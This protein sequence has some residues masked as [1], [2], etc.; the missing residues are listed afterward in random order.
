MG[1][2]DPNDPEV[3]EVISR[4]K[5]GTIPVV[6]KISDGYLQAAWGNPT[7]DVR[8]GQLPEAY[9]HLRNEHPFHANFDASRLSQA[10]GPF[11]G[12]FFKRDPN[13]PAVAGVNFAKLNSLGA[14]VRQISD[15]GWAQE[16]PTGTDDLY[17]N[18]VRFGVFEDGGPWTHYETPD[19]GDI[20][21]SVDG[22]IN[23]SATVPTT[24][25]DVNGVR[26]LEGTEWVVLPLFTS[27]EIPTTFNPWLQISAH[28]YVDAIPANGLMSFEI[29]GVAL[30]DLYSIGVRMDL[31]GGDLNLSSGEGWASTG[32]THHAG[33]APIGGIQLMPPSIEPV[34][35]SAPPLGYRYIA[36]QSLETGTV[37]LT[38]TESTIA[39]SFPSINWQACYL[40][41]VGYTLTALATVLPDDAADVSV[42]TYSTVDFDV[43]DILYVG[44][45]Q[46]EILTAPANNVFTVGRARN[47]TLHQL[48]NVGTLVRESV[49]ENILRRAYVW[50][51]HNTIE[52]G[53]RLGFI[54]LR[55]GVS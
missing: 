55:K 33:D 42:N 48:H 29:T 46:V 21:Y 27:P 32:R 15:T 54:G 51:T 36:A 8:D 17:W 6:Y 34:G 30:N 13:V 12:L 10:R 50:E 37:V 52:L 38:H 1:T 47:G 5:A 7:F 20:E 11:I 24:Y 35:N 49:T 39:G 19:T 31:T 16:P 14:Y 2:Y 41:F 43:G 3:A 28:D 23:W 18:I 40:A 25:S 26:I 9:W 4:V 22:G 53:T 44:A 45:E